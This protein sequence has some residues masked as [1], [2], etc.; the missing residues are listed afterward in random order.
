MP[1]IKAMR[2]KKQHVAGARSAPL[3]RDVLCGKVG[4]I[5]R[6]MEDE[7]EERQK[8]QPRIRT[9]I[10]SLTPSCATI[11]PADTSMVSQLIL[12]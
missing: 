1:T 8:R 12:M 7:G 9:L 6:R 5:E 4:A 3:P 11:A 10:C 2:G